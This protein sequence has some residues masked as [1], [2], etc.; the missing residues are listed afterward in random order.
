MK[1]SILKSSINYIKHYRVINKSDII[2]LE[3]LLKI[4]MFKSDIFIISAFLNF[5]YNEHIC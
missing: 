2:K 5:Y 1:N 4:I 3:C